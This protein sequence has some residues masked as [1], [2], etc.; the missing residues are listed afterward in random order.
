MRSEVGIVASIS[1]P[2]AHLHQV[3]IALDAT[4]D[5]DSKHSALVQ[6]KLRTLK[7]YADYILS[8]KYP[9]LTGGQLIDTQL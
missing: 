1:T 3:F 2:K 5:E 7:D 8:H 9:D 6:T 4:P